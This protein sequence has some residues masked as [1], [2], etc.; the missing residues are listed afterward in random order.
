MVN[1]QSQVVQLARRESEGMSESTLSGD[2]ATAMGVGREALLSLVIGAGLLF[3]IGWQWN[4]PL[5]AWLA[6]LFLMRFFRSQERWTST[7]I[8][9]PLMYVTL[10][11]STSGYWPMPRALEFVNAF[12]RLLP[13][14]FAFYLDRFAARQLTGALRILVFPCALVVADFLQAFG[15]IGSVFS[16]AATQFSNT[17][18]IQLSSVTGIWGITFLMGWFASTANALWE[19]DFDLR[20]TTKPVLAFAITLALVFFVGSVRTSQFRAAGETVRI[21]SVAIDFDRAII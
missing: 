11:Y 7:L 21:G 5:A 18:L 4:T 15:P 19:Q 13:L 14:I 8:A 10:W 16:P 17:P 9:L 1:T 20:A 12:I 2:Q 3:F 6:P